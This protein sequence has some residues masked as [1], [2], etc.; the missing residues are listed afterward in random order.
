MRFSGFVSFE[1]DEFQIDGKQLDLLYY[2]GNRFSQIKN[3]GQN[4]PV[5]FIW[6]SGG[7]KKIVI[8]NDSQ[9]NSI[10]ELKENFFE[11]DLAISIWYNQ[12]R[13]QLLVSRDIFGFTPLYY[14]CV[15]NDFFAFSTSL[16]D[17]LTNSRIKQ[18]LQ[19]NHSLV[20]R[21]LTPWSI[22]TLINNETMFSS[23]NCVLPGHYLEI[24]LKGSKQF[25]YLK[26][27]PEN[28]DGIGNDIRE[29]GNVFKNIFSKSIKNLIGESQSIGMH[30]SGGM[31]SSS[32]CSMVKSLYP[33]QQ[34]NTFYLDPLIGEN[35]DMPYA[36]EVVRQINSKHEIV[37]S[38]VQYFDIFQ[39]HIEVNA[40]PSM[41]ISGPVPASLLRE[42]AL[43][44]GCDVLLSG[45]GGDNVVG[46]GLEYLSNLFQQR[47][48]EQLQI[49][50]EERSQYGK[51]RDFQGEWEKLPFTKRE[52]LYFNNYIV[53]QLIQKK[54]IGNII[55]VLTSV[56]RFSTLLYYLNKLGIKIINK[57]KNESL[58]VFINPHLKA[59]NSIKDI[60]GFQIEDLSKKEQQDALG[61]VYGWTTLRI[62][63]EMGNMNE[64][65][66]NQHYPF[67][68]KDLF[69][70]SLAAP[71]EMKYNNGLT[72]GLLRE[73]MRGIIPA[74]HQTRVDKFAFDYF[75]KHVTLNLFKESLDLLGSNSDVWH[76]VH[77]KSFSKAV[78]IL[79]NGTDLAL[80]QTAKVYVLRSV[81]FAIWLN[82]LKNH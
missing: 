14:I 82:W 68:Q 36:R 51:P 21:Y 60:L 55:S 30:L 53:K 9:I 81:S 69:E 67:Y 29:F 33:S 10:E 56:G 15:E 63:E 11:L 2:S 6:E 44:S 75:S 40:Q 38:D 48:W 22:K 32:I 77:K 79:E 70:L 19:F 46:H 58:S 61:K 28:W 73:S 49:V 62:N 71:P 47:D 12:D 18:Y 41:M 25:S 35:S 17:L 27:R 66:I 13:K 42:A 7:Q 31:D 74:M 72:R 59:R 76:Y 39:K 78:K 57:I 34:L 37:F 4:R 5:F 16:S 45:H 24:N 52:E 23:I 64:N 26:Y 54:N 50:L 1:K 80:I 3:T 43:H 65:S 20:R 8:K